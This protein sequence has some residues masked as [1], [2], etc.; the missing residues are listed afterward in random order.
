[1]ANYR[2]TVPDTPDCHKCTHQPD[3]ARR[4]YE[5]NKTTNTQMTKNLLFIWAL[6]PVIGRA[7]T[8]GPCTVN[9][10]IGKVKAQKVWITWNE[11]DEHKLDTAD[12]SS[13]KASFKVNV[14]YPVS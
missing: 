5:L 8:A 7:Q 12:I 14:P 4:L 3:T 9:I 6:L 13:G 11:G 1:M 2:R 10:N